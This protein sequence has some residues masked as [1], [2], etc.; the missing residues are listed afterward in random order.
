M[1]VVGL[2]ALC[3]V[4]ADRCEYPRK[5]Y[6]VIMANAEL[7]EHELIKLAA[8]SAALADTLRLRGVREPASAARRSMTA[9][10]SAR[11][12]STVRGSS[13]ERWAI[14]RSMTCCR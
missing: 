6:A 4:F 8:L 14:S 12:S 2:D 3:E 11:A 7:R 9:A 5:R 13:G 1:L 10:I